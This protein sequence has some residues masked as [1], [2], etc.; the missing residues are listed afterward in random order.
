MAAEDAIRRDVRRELRAL[1]LNRFQFEIARQQ[2]AVA[3][4]QVDEAQSTIRLGQAND[5]SATLYLLSAFQS[6]LSAKNGLIGGWVA[7]ESSRMD[8]L[9]DLDWMEFDER[10]IWINERDTPGNAARQLQPRP[11]GPDAEPVVR[12]APTAGSAEELPPPT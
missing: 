9:R 8:L 4:R 6:L 5:R 3:A 11:P 7:Y 12:P 10:G 2:L 1:E